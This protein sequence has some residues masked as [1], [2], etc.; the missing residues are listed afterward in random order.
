L[1]LLVVAE[2]EHLQVVKLLEQEHLA[3]VMVDYYYLDQMELPTQVVAVVV[4]DMQ[5]QLIK[6][7]VMVVLEL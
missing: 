6:V 2:V 7:A 1:P 4:A 3:V 5:V